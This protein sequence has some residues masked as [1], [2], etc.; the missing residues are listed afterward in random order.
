M[1]VGVGH[2][3]GFSLPTVLYE[4][5]PRIFQHIFQLFWCLTGYASVL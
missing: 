3:S 5:N 1:V 2:R 4:T